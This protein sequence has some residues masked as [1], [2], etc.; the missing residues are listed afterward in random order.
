MAQILGKS[1]GPTQENAAN[2]E[3][4]AQTPGSGLRQVASACH[5]TDLP[6]IE[7]A[8][9]GMRNC[10]GRSDSEGHRWEASPIL[11][12]SATQPARRGYWGAISLSK[13]TR[14]VLFLA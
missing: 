14:S 13:L 6:L 12:L 1:T 9:L 5:R 10:G 11:L 2:S 7:W 3:G 4:L 8:F